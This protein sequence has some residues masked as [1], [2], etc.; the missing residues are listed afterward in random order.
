MR[1]DGKWIVVFLLAFSVHFAESADIRIECPLFFDLALD[2]YETPGPFYEY[3]FRIAIETESPGI[4]DTEITHPFWGMEPIVTFPENG[5]LIHS[6]FEILGDNRIH[7]EGSFTNPG[8]YTFAYIKFRGLKEDFCRALQ[9]APFYDETPIRYQPPAY[10]ISLQGVFNSSEGDTAIETN[11]TFLLEVVAIGEMI[12]IWTSVDDA[13]FMENPTL[14]LH[15][16]NRLPVREHASF[17]IP[18]EPGVIALWKLKFPWINNNLNVY[19]PL[20]V[21]FEL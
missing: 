21:Q 11:S 7:I 12:S 20:L 6:A 10:P 5:S 19:E 13:F 15:S 2:V 18:F 8:K 1:K 14:I 16:I 9:Y 17:I 3:T 4:F